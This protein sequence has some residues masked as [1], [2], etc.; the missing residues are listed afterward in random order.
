MLS[1][2]DLVLE[3][4]TVL[5]AI[6]KSKYLDT[7]QLKCVKKRANKYNLASLCQAPLKLMEK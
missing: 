7:D 6:Y 5:F 1:V 3:E 2:P 4:T